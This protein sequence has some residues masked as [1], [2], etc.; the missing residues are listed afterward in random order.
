MTL[1]ITDRDD[2]ADKFAALM[3]SNVSLITAGLEPSRELSKSM[4]SEFLDQFEVTTPAP[5]PAPRDCFAGYVIVSTV[6]GWVAT[7]FAHSLYESADDAQKIIDQYLVV[8]GTPDAPY[9]EPR[10]VTFR[11]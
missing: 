9:F 3:A 4:V 1:E 7:N 8:N 10:K 2:F 5:S 6:T 11:A